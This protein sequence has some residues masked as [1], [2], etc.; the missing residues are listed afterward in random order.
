MNGKEILRE[1]KSA[2]NPE[3]VKGMAR[4]GIN[5]KNTYGVSIPLLRKIAKKAGKNHLL[6][7]RL[8]DSRI[9]EARILAAMVDEPEKVT[10]GQME[11]WARE[12]D[13]W[14]VCDQVCMNLFDKTRLAHGKALEWSS[15][16]DEFVKRAGFSLMACIAFHDKTSTNSDFLGFLAA[17][18]RESVDDR[19]YVRKAVN[20][21]LRQIGKRNLEL[22]RIAV[23]TAREIQELESRSAK[24][25]ASDAIRELTSRAVQSRLGRSS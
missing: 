13:S 22:N 11:K 1:L 19:N 14:D 20:W 5:P 7:Q 2:A 21:A 3:A 8:W 9:H 18:R 16:R 6:A 4:F 15:R 24:W 17:I 25:V 12:F 10:E 23:K